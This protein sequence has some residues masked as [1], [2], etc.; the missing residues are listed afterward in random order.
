MKKTFIIILLILALI[1]TVMPFCAGVPQANAQE[2]ADIIIRGATVVTMDSSSRVIEDGAVAVRGS[3]I[4]AVG[5]S[6]EVA[7]RFRGARVIDGSGKI[8]MPGLI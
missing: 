8:V 1:V 2:R 4:I 3:T 6:S 5:G 7:A